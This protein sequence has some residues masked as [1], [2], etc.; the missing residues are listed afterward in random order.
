MRVDAVVLGAGVIGVSV[1][2]HLQMKGRA[3]VLIDRRGPAEETSYGN[4]GL[5]QREGVYPYGFPHDFGALLRY[6]WNNTIDAHY[7]P[8]AVF[9]L[10]PFLWEYWWQSRPKRHAE[11]ARQYAKLIE[12]CVTEHDALAEAAGATGFIHRTGWL[13]AFRTTQER[14]T[15]LAEAERWKRE[16]GLNFKALDAR[17]LAEA[18]PSLSPVLIGALHWTDPTAVND[19]GGLINA[20]AAISKSWAG[21]FSAPMPARWRRMAMA[22]ASRPGMAKWSLPAMLSSRSAPG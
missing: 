9:H 5:I 14:D 8:R 19:P 11:I 2:C 22:G 20:Y 7:H 13:K 1:A 15:R 4:A 6:A 17:Q 18:E 21:A 16:F 3:T 10:A 12:H